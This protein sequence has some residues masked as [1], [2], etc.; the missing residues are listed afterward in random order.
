MSAI[1]FSGSA[2]TADRRRRRLVTEIDS[3]LELPETTS[4]SAQP[5]GTADFAPF[6]MLSRD[7]LIRRVISPRLWK[8]VTV[9]VLLTLT[10]IIYAIVT[11]PSTGTS[12]SL[13]QALFASRLHAL[14]GLSGLK[15]FAAAQFCLLIAWVR[16]ASAVDFRGRYRWWRW[17]A[18]GLFAASLT[19][20][21]DS[22][23]W[24]M[25][26]TAECLEPLLGPVEAARPALVLVPAGAFLVILLR[27]L[28]PDMGR[29]RTA[30]SLLVVSIVLLAVRT[31]AGARQ[32]SELAMFQLSM[33]ELLVSGLMLSAFQLHAR[34]VIHVNPNPPL[35]V[36][37]KALSDQGGKTRPATEVKVTT[38]SDT[39]HSASV[40]VAGNDDPESANNVTNAPAEQQITEPEF[41]PLEPSTTEATSRSEVQSHGKNKS[42]KK[43]KYR[44]AG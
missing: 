10:P 30:Q 27:Q 38:E 3:E 22:R 12:A 4:D 40:V 24:I 13:D 15:F 17:M 25:N 7:R 31:F 23:Q 14:R 29:C 8:H 33:L 2:T 21:T 41:V 34:F 35:T 9:A 26:L 37:H 28:I 1:Q 36:Q 19:L 20:I 44:K 32:Y 42:N 39:I 11:W 5:E 6:P 18:A 16:S 43:A